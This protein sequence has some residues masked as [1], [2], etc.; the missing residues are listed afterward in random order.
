MPGESHGQ[1]S[2]AGYSPLGHKE[3]NTTE[4]LHFHFLKDKVTKFREVKVVT[5]TKC[6][7]TKRKSWDLN[8][9]L[10]DVEAEGLSSSLRGLEAELKYSRGK[11][12]AERLGR[13][14][15]TIIRRGWGAS[16]RCL[17]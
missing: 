16:F 13:H 3:S 6:T 12:W 8:W 2:L 15:F 9:G 17:A 10:S 14:F 11:V 7:S 4:R 1:R 5:C